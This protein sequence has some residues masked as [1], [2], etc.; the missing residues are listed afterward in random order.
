MKIQVIERSTGP[1][2]PDATSRSTIPPAVDF[3]ATP[4]ASFRS[5]PSA[6]VPDS[7]IPPQYSWV[8]SFG[9]HAVLFTAMTFGLVELQRPTAKKAFETIETALDLPQNLFESAILPL[10]EQP[11][12]QSGGDEGLRAADRG[13]ALGDA[14][15]TADVFGSLASAAPTDGLEA[16]GL[17]R[18]DDGDGLGKSLGGG[19]DAADGAADFF[20]AVAK[21]RSVVYV[22]DR[23]WSMAHFKARP[24]ELAKKELLDSLEKLSPTMEF[25]IIFYNQEP[26]RLMR[27]SLV[28][29]SVRLREKAR[30]D[31][32]QV[33]GQGGSNHVGALVMALNLR[34]DVIFYLSDVEDLS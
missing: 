15:E 27:G 5:T 26:Q 1:A 6:T 2:N 24:M 33:E 17:G 7:P 31:V 25:Q 10:D 28:E 11:A 8:V 19:N 16:G 20:G 13:P 3:A 22:I 14:A 21:G 9:F 12:M 29:A 23:S 30:E 4:T 34:P 32:M 18:G